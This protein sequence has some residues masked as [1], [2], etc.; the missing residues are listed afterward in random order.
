MSERGRLPD[1]LVIGAMKA[2]TTSLELYLDQHPQVFMSRLKEPNY[3]AFKEQ[4]ISFSDAFGRPS[5][6][7]ERSITD[8]SRYRSLFEGARTDQKAGEISHWYLYDPAAPGHIKNDIPDAR[9]IAVLRDPMERAYSEFLFHMRDG[10]ESVSDF[11]EALDLELER[12]AAGCDDGRYVD[13]GL[14]HA[15]LSRFFELFP[16]EQIRVYLFEDLRDDPAALIRD[17]YSFIDVDPSVQPDTS[18][19]RNISGIPKSMGMQRL[20]RAVVWQEGLREAVR[21]TPL[22]RPLQKLYADA[23]RRNLSRPPLP[24]QHRER[25]RA[26][27]KDDVVKLQGL[28]DRDLTAWLG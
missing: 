22:G 14:Y 11:G 20:L 23:S 6:L 16:R 19:S 25:L 26:A 5:R 10:R 2:G 28:I 18:V 24:P 3:F 13:R 12:I 8:T 4:S 17:L 21:R 15:Q 9:L 7:N 1:F 27:F